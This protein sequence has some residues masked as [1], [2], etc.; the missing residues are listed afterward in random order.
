MGAMLVLDMQDFH[1]LRVGR[2]ELVASGS[3]ASARVVGHCPDASSEELLRELA[4]MHR[5]DLVLAISEEERSMLTNIYALPADKVQAAP[6]GYDVSGLCGGLRQLPGFGQRRDVMFIGNWRHRPNRDCAQWLVREVWPRVHASLPEI[7]LSVYG[8]SP[9]PEDMAMT[10]NEIGVT[11]CGY[12]RSVAKVMLTHRL[13]VAPLRYGAGVK[14]KLTDAM[15][16]GLVAVTT[17]IGAEGLG[18]ADGFPGIVVP[19]CEADAEAF[20]QAVVKAY[21]EEEDWRLRQ[22][23]AIAFL[24]RHFDAK[25]N[26]EQLWKFFLDR[27]ELLDQARRQNFVGQLLLHESLRATE[28]KA[29]YL[30]AKAEMKL[31]QGGGS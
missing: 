19:S 8:S 23:Q 20:A 1:A 27:W 6:F 13:L 2:E 24:S 29:K 17:A 9:T 7:R 15:Y 25:K 22:E 30:A 26:G 10:N 31:A 21:T 3:V 16:N 11:I 18:S 4:A 5:C 28:W 14:G 12:C